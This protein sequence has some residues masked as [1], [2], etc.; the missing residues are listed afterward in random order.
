[1]LNSYELLAHI[2]NKTKSLID[3]IAYYTMVIDGNENG[4]CDLTHT[5]TPNLEMLS[6][7]KIRN[8]FGTPFAPEINM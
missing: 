7:L 2:R 8:I 1:M 4:L 3:P 6:H 5:H